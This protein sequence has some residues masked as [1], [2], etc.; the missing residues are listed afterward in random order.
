MT[1]SA[2]I[3]HYK[4]R[5]R[6]S[7]WELE[8]DALYIVEGI[9]SG[10][11]DCYRDD[12]IR[13]ALKDV[14]IRPYRTDIAYDNIPCV[15]HAPHINAIRKREGLEHTKMK[16]GVTTYWLGKKQ[17]YESIN[18]PGIERVS[19]KLFR[20]IDVRRELREIERRIRTLATAWE[21]VSI[22]ERTTRLRKTLILISRLKEI[23][24]TYQF[25]PWF[26][27]TELKDRLENCLAVS[28]CMLTAD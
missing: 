21:S 10:T 23:V 1:D 24:L 16:E 9:N 6:E 26:S 2:S 14:I 27:I 28:N 22:E 17:T 25:I 15:A 19:M 20:D 5:G 12:L 8:D 18:S 3:N 11:Y 4:N 7:L 13:C